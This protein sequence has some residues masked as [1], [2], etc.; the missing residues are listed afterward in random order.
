MAK[1]DWITGDAL[2]A[3]T[4]V[5]DN[6]ID[7]GVIDP[8]Y[9]GAVPNC[10]WNNRRPPVALWAEVHRVLKPGAHIAVFCFP[11]L[12][13][14]FAQDLELAGFEIRNSWVWHYPNGLP[15][16]Q[17]LNDEVASRLR[18]GHEAILVARK[19][20][21]CKTY[22]ANVEKWGTGGLRTKNTLG[23]GKMSTTVFAYNKPSDWERELGTDGLPLRRV[24]Q[25]PRKDTSGFHK[26]KYERRNFHYCVKP[27]ALLTHLL[28]I[29]AKPG[30]TV[31]DPF[32]GSGSAGMAAVWAGMNYIG[33]DLDPD[34]VRIAEARVGHALENPIPDRLTPGY[35]APTKTKRKTQ[36]KARKK[37]PASVGADKPALD[38]ATQDHP[39]A[40]G[41]VAEPTTRARSTRPEARTEIG[42]GRTTSRRS[43][44]RGNL[45]GT[46]WQGL[47]KKPRSGDLGASKGSTMTTVRGSRRVRGQRR[48]SRELARR[49]GP[50]RVYR[51]SLRRSSTGVPIR[52]YH[53]LRHL[54]DIF[55]NSR[56]HRCARFGSTGFK[57]FTVPEIQAWNLYATGHRCVGQPPTIRLNLRDGQVERGFDNFVGVLVA[58]ENLDAHLYRFV[59][60]VLP[61][62]P[63]FVADGIP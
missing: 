62:E 3:M 40:R 22:K 36:P 17:P 15:A 50:R 56:D 39:K 55:G 26:S 44:V 61:D 43:V 12:A 16:V 1:I 59:A 27:V 18:P 47:A 2:N 11:Q 37:S 6:S 19:K 14:T 7:G 33:I 57:P 45:L 38:R 10:P 29:I 8:P 58:Q 28:K 9:L 49:F 13:H 5:P 30:D 25:K 21:D 42:E 41:T 53:S 24:N 51:S 4:C 31:I 34:Y 52:R 20:T 48:Q 46:V 60:S 63:G 32:M 35:V 54:M 23:D